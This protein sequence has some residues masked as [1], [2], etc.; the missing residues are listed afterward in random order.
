MKYI[1][2]PKQRIGNPF[3]LRSRGNT[4]RFYIIDSYTWA[5]TIQRYSIVTFP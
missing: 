4:Q 2:A 3:L 1:V 5:T